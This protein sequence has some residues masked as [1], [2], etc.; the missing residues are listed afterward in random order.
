MTNQS[1]EITTSA[2][3]AE[4]FEAMFL[5]GGAVMTGRKRVLQIA[6]SVFVGLFAPLGAT[7]VVWILV[8]MFGGPKLGDLHVAVVPVTLL[9]FG[10][11]SLW[12]MK[13]IY[14]V[15]ARVTSETKFVRGQRVL[16][17]ASGITQI[18]AHSCWHSGWGDVIAVK[19]GKTAIAVVISGVAIA[20]P[21]NAFPNPP[22]AD[23]ALAAMQSWQEAA[24]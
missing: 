7:M 22:E 1:W 8:Q 15:V 17:D 6:H 14:F 4:T 12:L 16:I 21:R 24:Q 19:A 2:T 10:F 18:T 23:R 9:V 11:I 5:A 3:A 20:L 13:E